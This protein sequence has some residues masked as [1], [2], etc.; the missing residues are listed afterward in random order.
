[1]GAHVNINGDISGSGKLII[2]Q[3]GWDAR[4][5][6]FNGCTFENLTGTIEMHGINYEFNKN[7]GT[8]KGGTFLVSSDANVLTGNI[9]IESG[10]TWIMNNNDD[11]NLTCLSGAT[12]GGDGNGKVN[13][14]TLNENV[15]FRFTSDTALTDVSTEYVALTVNNPISGPLP[16]LENADNERGKWKLV[17]REIPAETEEGSPTYQLVASFRPKGFVIII[18]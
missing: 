17:V 12:I 8:V 15:K 4:S 6:K 14:L 2:Y 3:K 9:T 5:I 7:N 1:M 18:D 16:L 13:N 10:V 11:Y